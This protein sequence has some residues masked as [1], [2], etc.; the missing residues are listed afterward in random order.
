MADTIKKFLESETNIITFTTGGTTAKQKT[1]TKSAKNMIDESNDIFEA[2]KLPKGLEFI[3][4][5]TPEHLFGYTFYCVLP[6][7]HGY[8]RKPERINYP[9]DLKIKNALLVT[10]PSFLESMRKFDCTPEVCPEIIITAGAKLEKK[11]FEYAKKISNRVIEIYGS[12]ETGVIAYR[13]NPDDEMKLFK[14]IEILSLEDD[15]VKISSKYSSNG[16]DILDDKIEVKGDRI[17]FLQRSGRTL[18]IQEKRVNAEEIESEIKSHKFVDECYTL[19][20][21]GKLAALVVMNNKGINFVVEN[22]T[23]DL[24]KDLKK[25]LNKKFEIVPQRWRFTDEIP[26]KENGKID[27]KKIEEVFNLNLSFPLMISREYDMLYAQFEMRFLKTSN[28][29]QGHFEGFPVLPGVVQLYFASYFIKDAFGID[30]H[31]G[32]LRKIK[33]T[34]IIRPDGI[35]YLRLEKVK[36]GVSYT[37][38]GDDATY[39]SGLLPLTNYL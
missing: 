29:F 4:T 34:N 16:F 18:K 38:Y 39:S 36:N 26:R 10:T 9:E 12:T 35:V 23:L 3:T 20:H 2:L 32:Q 15:K 17:K 11:T 21:D 14:G 25:R 31:C 28:F 37:F 1:V 27:R 24:I 22:S 13:E 8:K 33:F 6:T 30:C 7:L 5:T 19:E